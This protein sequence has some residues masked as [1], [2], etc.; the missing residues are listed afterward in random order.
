MYETTQQAEKKYIWENKMNH[1]KVKKIIRAILVMVVAFSAIIVINMTTTEAASFSISKK[2]LVLAKG[3]TKKL[4]VSNKPSSAK[5]TW[6]SSNAYAAKVSKKGKVKALK[7][8]STIITAKCKGKSVKCYVTIPDGKRTVV[9]NSKAATL[10]EGEKWTI[11][12][13]VNGKKAAPKYYSENTMIASVSSKGVVSAFN[14]GTTT[15]VVYTKYGY[16]N[17]VIT[18]SSADTQAVNNPEISDRSITAIRMC[19]ANYN[20]LYSEIVRTKGMQFKLGLDNVDEKK[21]KSIVWNTQNP[22]IVSAPVKIA[23]RKLYVNVTAMGAGKTNVSATVTYTAGN[24]VTYTCTVYVSDPKINRTSIILYDYTA[25]NN[26]EQFVELT[27]VSEKSQIEWSITGNSASCIYYKTKAA[28]TGLT[29]SL[30]RLNSETATTVGMDNIIQPGTGTLRAVVD[31]V[32]L[33]CQYTVVST[34]F[35]GS[36]KVL[37]KGKKKQIKVTGNGTL[38]VTYKSRNKKVATVSKTGLVT[39]ISSGVTYI[40]VKIGTKTFIYRIEVSAKGVRKIIK[41]STYIVNNWTYSQGRRMLSRFYDCSSLV[42]KGYKSYKNY[43]KK[44]GSSKYAL[45]AAGLFDYLKGK[46]Q[47]VYY[48]YTKTDDLRPGDLVFYG[49]YANAVRYSTPGRTLNI[50]HVAMYV[51]NGMMVEKGGKP[52]SYNGTTYIVGIGRVAK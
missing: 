10:V 20:Y 46:G 47:L 2:T 44:L 11:K 1:T 13:T 27:G 19:T 9:L 15:I 12:A 36:S 35:N 4:K 52:L 34:I 48:G 25:G 51:G 5:V 30:T 50:Y 39:A 21:V 38:P 18:V 29:S 3:K 22:Q 28:L 14:P 49:N 43:H 17:C 23:N 41:R 45:T 24:T 31:G 33:E 42:W 8:G 16:E 32:R 37:A 6:K 7:S 40:N 26:R